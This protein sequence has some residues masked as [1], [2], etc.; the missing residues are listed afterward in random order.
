MKINQ[1]EE[2]VGITKK[3]I[4]FY[5]EQ[6][7]ISPERNPDNGYREYSLRDV[8]QLHK[9]KLFR[10]LDIPIDQ[11][12]KMQDG[13]ISLM[14]CLESQIVHLSHAQHSLELMK[15]ICTQMAE[16]E[17]DISKLQPEGYFDTIRKMEE[18]GVRFM[19]VTRTDVKKKGIMPIVIAVIVI[20]FFIA[21]SA[22]VVWL[23][24]VQPE[25]PTVVPVI[26]VG[27]SLLFIFAVVYVLRQRLNEIKGGEL[28]EASKY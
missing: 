7:L 15:E 18:G 25:T 24:I 19:N 17:S 28:D 12:R 23:S 20:A 13:N 9:I 8:E 2:L 22:V 5:E 4:R 14:E 11:I 27:T 3:N 26:S 10:Q 6:G 21:I 16:K 1:V